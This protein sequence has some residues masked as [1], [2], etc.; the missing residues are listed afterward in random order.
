MHGRLCRLRIKIE[1]RRESETD[2]Q[3]E[4]ERDRQTDRQTDRD[5]EGEQQQKLPFDPRNGQK[6]P[7]L[8]YDGDQR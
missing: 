2:R 7:V 1:A 8:E 3:I 6:P 4:T 5:R